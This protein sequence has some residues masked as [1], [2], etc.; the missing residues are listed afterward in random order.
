M[1]INFFNQD[2][3]FTLKQKR[4]IKQWISSIVLSHNKKIGFI[5]YI[6]CSDAEILKINHQYLNHNYYTDIITFPYNEADSISADIFIS[7]E[8]VK[9]NSAKFNQNFRLELNRVM[10]HGVLHLL[11]YNDYTNEERKEMRMKEDKYI[12]LL[13]NM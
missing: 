2:I 7:I 12:D 11:G 10:V 4:K 1:A 13:E 3:H 5:N 9:T 8:T 6:F